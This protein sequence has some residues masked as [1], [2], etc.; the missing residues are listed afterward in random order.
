MQPCYAMIYKIVKFLVL[1]IAAYCCTAR[2]KPYESVISGVLSGMSGKW[3]Y[4]EEL[5]VRTRTMIDSLRISPEG[6]FTFEVAVSD[7]GFFI[8]R[9]DPE[10]YILL[11]MEPDEK[12][13]LLINDSLF[14]TGTSI[15]NS[16]QSV[17]I[18][19][20]EAIISGQKAKLDSLA[21]VY[22]QSKDSPNFLEM[23]AQLD[24]AFEILRSDQRRYNIDFINKNSGSL[25]SLIV[26]NR[27]LG[28]NVVLDEEEDFIYFHRI[29]SA[30][31]ISHPGN[32]HT[33]DHHKRVEEIR[34]RI[35]DKFTADEKLKPGKKAPNFVVSD[36]SGNLMALKSYFGKKILIYFWAGW[37]AKARQDNRKLV[38]FYPELKKRNIELFGVSMDE[39]PVIWKGALK[40]DRLPGIQGSDLKG[41]E[42]D[43]IKDYNLPEDI[44]NYCLIDEQHK[45]IFRSRDFNETE[46]RITEDNL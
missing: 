4:L 25:A 35:F 41:F 40:L 18:Y 17:L 14:A 38:G 16:P 20:F 22:N 37:N 32:K 30:L 24:S 11:V 2:Y 8:V 15:G 7:A 10:N 31:M 6:K 27:K 44:L 23:K 43:I 26:L 34:G 36:T 3:L 39:N 29:D 28:N 45:I 19:G 1:I 12:I 5:D 21:E 13:E 46:K 33:L 9:T 42:S